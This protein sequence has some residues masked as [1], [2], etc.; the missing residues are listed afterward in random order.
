[1]LDFLKE[2][3]TEKYDIVCKRKTYYNVKILRVE[4]GFMLIE[5]KNEDKILLNI[6]FISSIAAG[7]D[8]AFGTIP[9]NLHL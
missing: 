8:L 4:N 1:M 6:G 5:T 9:K 2:L 7:K 3:N